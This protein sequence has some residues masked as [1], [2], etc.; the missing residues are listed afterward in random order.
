MDFMPH[1]VY[2]KRTNSFLGRQSLCCHAYH[3][4]KKAHV[5]AEVF[6]KSWY[7]WYY[8][9]C[10]LH[11][12]QVQV[13]DHHEVLGAEGEKS[14]LPAGPNPEKSCA[15][16]LIIISQEKKNHS[17]SWFSSKNA[18]C[19]KGVCVVFIK[20]SAKCGKPRN[21]RINDASHSE[22]ASPGTQSFSGGKQVEK[23][24][25]YFWEHFAQRVLSWRSGPRSSRVHKTAHTHSDS[26]LKDHDPSEPIRFADRNFRI[27]IST[28]SDFYLVK[29]VWNL[30]RHPDQE[31][32]YGARSKKNR[33]V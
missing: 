33:I 1:C 20:T 2:F 26:V 6:L 25:N 11:I 14:V 32:R 7:Y 13:H 17:K 18:R 4:V 8:H 19:Y 23:G 5:F 28:L 31:D 9:Q 3:P 30:V 22:E 27:G 16:V 29:P 10:V 24:S 15:M 21:R 12:G